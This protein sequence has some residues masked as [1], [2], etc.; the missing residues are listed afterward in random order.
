MLEQVESPKRTDRVEKKRETVKTNSDRE[1]KLP[2]EPPKVQP[3]KSESVKP[4]P[5]KEAVRPPD[6]EPV[7]LA[8]PAIKK[9]WNGADSGQIRW[10]N[11]LTPGATVDLSRESALEG[12]SKFPWYTETRVRVRVLSPPS[13]VV[14]EIQPS[15]ANA[16]DLIRLRNV[17]GAAV[18]VVTLVWEIPQ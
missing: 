8:K 2:P 1:T 14:I 18:P 10:R 5:P 16:W 12:G 15:S 3:V 4:E 11:P 9:I 13:G 17:S 6:P 7:K